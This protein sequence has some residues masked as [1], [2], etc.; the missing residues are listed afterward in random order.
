MEL[1]AWLM[2]MMMVTTMVA[3]LFNLQGNFHMNC[4]IKSV[5]VF[6]SFILSCF[7]RIK[8][9]STIDPSFFLPYFQVPRPFSGEHRELMHLLVR[10][11]EIQPKD[12]S[13][14][15]GFG[16]LF[17]VRRL[18]VLILY[19]RRGWEGRRWRGPPSLCP[20]FSKN[21]FSRLSLSVFSVVTP[22]LSCSLIPIFKVCIF[23]MWSFYSN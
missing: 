13:P 14:M 1:S 3:T 12:G 6:Q 5:A 15:S 23:L 17:V 10:S 16:F 22:L 11:R 9:H 19:S 18:H 21:F 20:F 8:L 4:R 7:A 2:V